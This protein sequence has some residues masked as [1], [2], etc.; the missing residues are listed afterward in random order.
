[1]QFPHEA[2]LVVTQRCVLSQATLNTKGPFFLLP[3]QQVE[4]A[5]KIFLL[6]RKL[7]ANI[8]AEISQL[9]LT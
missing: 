9:S 8:L 3:S 7:L 6:F 4:I 1:M 2:V 5:Q